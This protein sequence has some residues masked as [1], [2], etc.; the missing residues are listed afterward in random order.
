MPR[1]R[2]VRKRRAK[3]VRAV[4]NKAL[5]RY[6]QRNVERKYFDVATGASPVGVSTTAT[7]YQ[8]CSVPPGTTLTTRIGNSLIMKSLTIRYWIAA[9]TGD[10]SNLVRIIVF[11]WYPVVIS[12]PQPTDILETSDV[13]SP[14]S[15][16]SP[17]QF[18][19]MYDKT[20]VVD[21]DDPVRNRTIKFFGRRIRKKDLVFN[22][23]G[24]NS[25]QQN[26]IQ[27]LLVSDS[28]AAAH[29]FVGFHARLTYT[30]Q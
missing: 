21:A 12:T 10:L 16:S 7:S 25:Q 29:P 4:V 6:T 11:Q 8:I 23:S 15:H 9:A 13:L 24:S 19:V 30:D 14:Y 5:K 2:A 27:I 1:R 22:Q 17:G 26:G 20:Y 3:G 28:G 18:H